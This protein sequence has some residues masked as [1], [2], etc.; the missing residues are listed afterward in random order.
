LLRVLSGSKHVFLLNNHHISGGH[1]DRIADIL[2]AAAGA[3]LP[4]LRRFAVEGLPTCGS[5]SDVLRRCGV[6]TWS[7]RQRVLR[8]LSSPRAKLQA[9]PNS[10]E[11]DTGL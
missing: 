8:M 9:F 6:D 3:D 7:L 11:A 4:R 1:G 5:Q 10:F 2:A